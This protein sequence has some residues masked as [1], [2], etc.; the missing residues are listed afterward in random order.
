MRPYLL[1]LLAL[2]LTAAQFTIQENVPYGMYSGA[3]LA[4]WC[5]ATGPGTTGT[6]WLVFGGIALMTTIMLIL[7]KGWLGKDFKT[8]AS[9]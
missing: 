2:P 9:A 5:P 1:A 7:A 8:K 6:M 3:A 4:K